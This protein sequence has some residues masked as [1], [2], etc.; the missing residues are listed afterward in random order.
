MLG[1]EFGIETGTHTPYYCRKS[2]YGVD[3]GSIIMKY[4]HKLLDMVWIK[5]CTTDG[6][7]SPIV[8]APTLHQEHVMD[9]KD[10]V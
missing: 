2:S 9:I 1:Y 8:L 7:C 10:F 6:W 3:E 4:I 5:E